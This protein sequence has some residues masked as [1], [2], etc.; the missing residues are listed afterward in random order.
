M[1]MAGIGAAATGAAVGGGMTGLESMA[2][3]I[4][5]TKK[6]RKEARRQRHWAQWMSSTAYQRA[7][8]DMKKAGLN[9]ALMYGGGSAAQMGS[10][11]AAQ[12]HSGRGGVGQAAVAGA[13][14]GMESA[15]IR[16]NADK[17]KAETGVAVSHKARLD[18]DRKVGLMTEDYIKNQA[19]TLRL[20]LPRLRNEAAIENSELGPAYSWIDRVFAGNGVLGSNATGSAALKAA[21][22][23]GVLGERGIRSMLE[24]ALGAYG[25]A[26]E[27]FEASKLSA[28]KPNK[29]PRNS[30]SSGGNKRGR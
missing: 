9:P 22:G 25:T 18:Q 1:A 10:G 15:L 6:A 20:Q 5:G 27:K 23:A 24:H 21:L 17:A 26:K 2:G 4:Y 19:E 14:A 7:T 8:D 12:A 11:A 3:N 28:P 16:A 29:K 13:R 30:G